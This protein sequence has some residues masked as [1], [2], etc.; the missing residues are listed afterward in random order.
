MYKKYKTIGIDLDNTVWNL[1]ET[2]VNQINKKYNL[3]IDYNDCPYN[4]DETFNK[5]PQITDD[6]NDLYYDAIAYVQI[7]KHA[8]T[9]IEYLKK[10]YGATI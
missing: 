5:Y 6:I 2:V 9:A 3:D 10:E 8:L 1:G 7:Y 4:L